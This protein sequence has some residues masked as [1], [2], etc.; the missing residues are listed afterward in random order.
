MACMHAVLHCLT[1][2]AVV[3]EQEG[4]RILAAD[5]DHYCQDQLSQVASCHDAGLDHSQNNSYKDTNQ[6]S[7]HKLIN[8]SPACYE[9]GVVL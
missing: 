7:T 1:V 6:E 4:A 8:R 2:G 5:D 3:K 9:I